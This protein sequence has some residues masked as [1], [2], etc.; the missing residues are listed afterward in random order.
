MNRSDT[1]KADRAFD[2][3]R[4]ESALL[5]RDPTGAGLDLPAWLLAQEEEVD[6]VRRGAR[7]AGYRSLLDSI[8]PPVDL[9]LDDIQNELDQW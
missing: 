8:L 7:S 4:E 2:L 1:A 9:R 5:M 3:L 6:S